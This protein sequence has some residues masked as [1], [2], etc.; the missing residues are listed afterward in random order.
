MYAHDV[1]G[2]VEHGRRNA[3]IQHAAFFATAD[4]RFVA[5][6]HNVQWDG[7]G[8]EPRYRI[9]LRIDRIAIRQGEIAPHVVIKNS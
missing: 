7:R 6:F 5:I 2:A 9:R 1:D 8:K 3:A 4:R